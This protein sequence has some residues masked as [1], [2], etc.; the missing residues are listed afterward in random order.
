MLG[1]GV[2][3]C[4]PPLARPPK[5]ACCLWLLQILVR[6][7]PHISTMSGLAAGCFSQRTDTIRN[8]DV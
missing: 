4:F 7:S 2:L 3:W 1:Q 8:C 6:V 5:G